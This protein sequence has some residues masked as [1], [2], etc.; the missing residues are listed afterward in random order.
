[1]DGCRG[2]S[3]EG[4]GNIAKGDDGE[5]RREK[6]PTETK[7]DEADDEDDEDRRN[8]QRG[9]DQRVDEEGEDSLR[10]DAVEKLRARVRIVGKAAARLFRRI[11]RYLIGHDLGL[12]GRNGE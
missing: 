9:D 2:R 10:E 12:R 8:H 5:E 7:S 4:E 3:A 1:A 6:Q 11:R